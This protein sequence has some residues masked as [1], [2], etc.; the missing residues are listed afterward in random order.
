MQRL[1]AYIDALTTGEDE[2]LRHLMELSIAAEYTRYT[3]TKED[4]W[5]MT[6]R[7]PLRS[8]VAY[9]ETHDAPESFHVDEHYADNP[10]ASFGIVEAQLHRA[11]GVTFDMFLGLSKVIRDVFIAFARGVP[12]PDDERRRAVDITTHFFDKF[13][14]G[15]CSEWVRHNE[16]DLVHELQEKNRSLTNEKNKYQLVFRSMADPALVTNRE[17]RV[18]EANGALEALVGLGEGAATGR[19]CRDLMGCGDAE[20]CPLGACLADGIALAGI[21]ET[22][23]PRGNRVDVQLSG[24]RITDISGKYA[25]AVAIFQDVTDRK[26]R[27]DDLEQ[28]VR[29]RTRALTEA[30]NALAREIAER[31]L[32]EAEARQAN[33][34][35]TTLIESTTDSI[36][37]KDLEGR[38]LVI[39]K[40]GSKFGRLPAEQILGHTDACLFTSETAQS[41]LAS[42]RRIIAGGEVVTLEEGVVFENGDRRVFLATKGPLRDHAGNVTGLFGISRD[43]TE[44]KRLEESFHQSQRMDAIGTM[45]GGI[46][47]DFTNRMV[48]ILGNADVLLSRDVSAE[49]TCAMLEEIVAAARRAG[50][51][52]HQMVAFARG[53][54]VNPKDMDLNAAIRGALRVQRRTAP[55]RVRIEEALPDEPMIIKADPT[56]LGMVVM[57]LFLN[58]VE[59][60]GGKGTVRVSTDVV[61]DAAAPTGGWVRLIVEDT[62]SGM[63]PE[64]QQHIFEPFFSTKFIGRGLGLAAVYGIVKNHGG[65]IDVFSSEGEGT[66][67]AISFPRILAQDRDAGSRPVPPARET[68]LLVDDEAWVLTTGSRML[69][70]L[71][72]RVL[73]A[74]DGREAVELAA[75][76]PGP[77]AAVVLDLGMPVMGGAE[78]FY[79]LKKLHRGELRVLLC[80]G[81]EMDETARSLLADGAIGFLRKPFVLNELAGYLRTGAGAAQGATPAEGGLA[82]Q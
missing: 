67:F 51:L 72:Y 10:A 73:T 4:D 60:I 40:A 57:N 35:F 14:L 56:Q 70:A 32:A 45:A 1:N 20:G 8:L 29:E 46:A 80:S 81:Y 65:Q 74:R 59:S 79:E 2:L 33:A 34:L 66:R 43:I 78:A 50:E 13:E 53:G 26:R 41:L 49:E 16:N 64:T 55:P 28:R 58:A 77:I 38:Y 47:L 48:P 69:D 6:V 63:S 15:F 62:G 31:R 42:D 23:Y 7:A 37:I 21:E 82:V 25:G 5:R 54:K 9:L 22:I 68:V 19:A 18:V 44:F 76:H 61:S 24:G 11:R 52:A 30:H 71:G 27:E 75:S 12:Q 3:S 39:N 17:M 36:F